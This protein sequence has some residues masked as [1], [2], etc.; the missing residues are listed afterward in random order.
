[1][2]K[3][4]GTGPIPVIHVKCPQL[5]NGTGVF[6]VDTGANI[7]IISKDALAPMKIEKHDTRVKSC[8]GHALPIKG[9][10]ILNCKTKDSAWPAY[11]FMVTDQAFSA[12]HGIIGTDI[13]SDLNATLN[14]ASQELQINVASKTKTVPLTYVHLAQTQEASM[15]NK[16]SPDLNESYKRKTIQVIAAD[17]MYVPAWSQTYISCR[18][19]N[20]PWLNVPHY[21]EKNVLHADGVI[22]GCALIKIGNDGTFPVPVIN[23]SDKP[24]K[25]TKHMLIT[26]ATPFSGS[27]LGTKGM[28]LLKNANMGG[29]SRENPTAET[30]G[31]SPPKLSKSGNQSAPSSGTESSSVQED[32]DHWDHDYTIIKP[33]IQQTSSSPPQSKHQQ[34]S[35]GRD[36]TNLSGSDGGQQ[37]SVGEHSPTRSPSGTP[38]GA[39]DNPSKFKEQ[40]QEYILKK[41]IREFL[42]QQQQQQEPEYKS[43]QEPCS[44]NKEQQAPVE[45]KK[46]TELDSSYTSIDYATAD[47]E[48]SDEDS[49]EVAEEE[50]LHESQEPIIT[51]PEDDQILQSNYSINH[52]AIE[53]INDDR[54]LK[55][56]KDDES[57]LPFDESLPYRILHEGLKNHIHHIGHAPDVCL[58]WIVQD[59]EKQLPPVDEPMLTPT[60]TAPSSN[61]KAVHA[62]QLMDRGNDPDTITDIK[63]KLA[64]AAAACEIDERHKSEFLSLLLNYEEIF[65]EEGD[66]TH[67]CPLFEQAIPLVDDIPVCIP[68]YPLPQAAKEGMKGRITEFLQAGVIRP[69][70]S[71]Y[72]APVWMVPKKDG[73]W[74]MCVDFREL[75]K[76][77]LNDPFPLPRI[78]ELLDEFGGTEYFSTCDLFWGFYHVKVKDQ[79]THKLAFST[80]EGRFEFLQLP[81]GLKLSP[82]VFQ[83][84]MN[85]VFNDYLRKFILVYMDDIVIYSKTADQHLNDLEQVFNRMKQAGLRFKVEKC[86]FFQKELP[87][88]GFL[89]SKEGI[90]L[91][92][93]KVEAVQNFPRPDKDLGQ[94]QSFLG[95]VGYFKRHIKDYAVKA[96]PLYNMLKGEDAHKKKRKGVV[97]TPYKTQVWGEEQEKAF[98]ALKEAATTAPVLAY[99]D[100]SKPFILTTDASSYALGFVL[101]QEFADGEHP[102]AYGSR[103]L[104]GSELNYGN[105][106]REM[107][108]VTQGVQHFRTYLYGRPFIIRTDHQAIPMI[109]KGKPTSRRVLKWLMEMEDYNY[110]LQY[111][112]ATKI[113]HADALSRMRPNEEA[114][115]NDDSHDPILSQQ[116][117][118]LIDD[119]RQWEPII[120]HEEWVEDQRNEPE[121]KSKLQLAQNPNEV[122]FAMKNNILYQQIDE[123]YVPLVPRK[124]RKAMIAKFHDP[125]VMGHQGAERTFFSMKRYMYWPGMRQDIEAYVQGCDLCQRYKRSYLKIPM[126]RQFIPPGAFHTV[127]MDV[128]GPVPKS[129]FGEEYIL[130]MQDLLTRWVELAPLRRADA[131]TMIDK[132]ITY[133]VLRY[134]P[135]VRL[136]TDRGS[137]FTGEAMREYCKLFGIHKLETTAYRP[138]GNGA[139]ERMHAELAKFFGM[140]LD[141]QSKSKWRW[142]LQ[143]A[144]WAYNTSYHTVLG[145]SPYEAVHGVIPSLG[146]LGVPQAPQQPGEKDH[147]ER[148]LGMRRKQLLARQKMIQ[149]NLMKSQTRQL[150]RH[151]RHAHKIPFKIGDLV[152]Q[153]NHRAKGKWDPRYLG[154]W[155][156]VDQLSPV[157][158]ELDKNGY[159]VSVHAAH[160]KAYQESTRDQETYN[161]TIPQLSVDSEEEDDEYE[162]GEDEVIYMPSS[163]IRYTP[164]AERLR[165]TFN[166]SRIPPS[167]TTGGSPQL[168]I[169]GTAQQLLP[170]SS[171]ISS[172]PRTRHVMRKLKYFPEK[173]RKMIVRVPRLSRQLVQDMNS[174]RERLNNSREYSDE[175]ENDEADQS[176]DY[177]PDTRADRQ[178]VSRPSTDQNGQ[179]NDDFPDVRRSMRPRR[180][181]QKVYGDDWV[182]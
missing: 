16:I 104:R 159:R 57:S 111:T 135:P 133:W 109:A 92:P 26:L 72:N 10:V 89:I 28:A 175:A 158:F 181:N 164:F 4:K 120:N 53:E 144:A 80:D 168:A 75:N 115:L 141:Q 119:G 146:I 140:Y 101:S 17:T 138:Q 112:P 152:L 18:I 42:S 132:F 73:K 145:M 12:F 106:D 127:T 151:N 45:R 110:I 126:Q 99:P 21:V 3:H 49:T 166:A 125:P 44:G 76:K 62:V 167:A 91:D 142:I 32:I 31:P 179:Q 41:Q 114:D 84:M 56:M 58:E 27:R 20:T 174:A 118:M 161:S 147:I 70:K 137:I 69:S 30:G 102:I 46:P 78:D 154:P 64:K 172:S 162:H 87:F 23:L 63:Q 77:I 60:A 40:I 37:Q 14:C 8:S 180:D 182:N 6:L 165:G 169:Q 15:I 171:P 67:S 22:T 74:R 34:S 68:Q 149:E 139:N 66:P 9:R 39:D 177:E 148:F 122:R 116:V 61:N 178:N 113:K 47:E 82:A 121:F 170:S 153:R 33:K 71:A 38:S 136:L 1:M 124:Y 50:T 54:N 103:L 55:E 157:V 13:L 117:A 128:V 131:A 7:S 94:L 11:H 2:N 85:L 36:A 130:V 176:S 51:E 24:F 163:R 79:D 19:R 95:M 173:L 97:E 108:A 65:R 155:R 98:L 134:G 48:S 88:L 123:K 143:Q 43:K 150:E 5:T 29:R 25:V 35:P 93:G 52:L 129:E 59:L 83:R 81:M 105:T 156:I 86:Q 90:R 107:L 100:F 96:K 160:L